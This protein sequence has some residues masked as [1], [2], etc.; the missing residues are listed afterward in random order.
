VNS[1][2]ISCKKILGVS[3]CDGDRETEFLTLCTEAYGQNTVLRYLYHAISA[4]RYVF[5]LR[6]KKLKFDW[7][8]NATVKEA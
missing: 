4:F 3:D 2:K 6:W 8:G 1:F 5:P 7:Y